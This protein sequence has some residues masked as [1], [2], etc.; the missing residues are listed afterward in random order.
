MDSR[1]LSPCNDMTPT[2]VPVLELVLDLDPAMAMNAKVGLANTDL[3]R[4]RCPDP[5]THLP[6]RRWVT[7][8]AR[9]VETFFFVGVGIPGVGG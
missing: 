8:G 9:W 1:L 6:L 4:D 5:Y 2:L 3:A 7:R